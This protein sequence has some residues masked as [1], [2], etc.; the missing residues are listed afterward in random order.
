MLSISPFL[1]RGSIQDGM[2]RVYWEMIADETSRDGWSWGMTQAILN[3]KRMYV[4]DALRGE[5]LP[6]FVVRAD[7]LLGAFMEL[8]RELAAD[9]ARQDCSQS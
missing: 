1:E 7:A 3:G 6:R 5:L 9:E 2:S 8:K 4:V